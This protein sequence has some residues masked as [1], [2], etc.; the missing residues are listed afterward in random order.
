MN[1]EIIIEKVDDSVT[2]PMDSISICL[3]EG[4]IFQFRSDGILLN[5]KLHLWEEI[6]W[7]SITNRELL[8]KL[9]EKKS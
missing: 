6:M 5:G 8:R 4:D 9:K 3:E 1:L 7:V 2:I